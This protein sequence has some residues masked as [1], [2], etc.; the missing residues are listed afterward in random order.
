MVIPEKT[1]QMAVLNFI[2]TAF[3][4]TD[5]RDEISRIQPIETS[6]PTII[7]IRDIIIAIFGLFTKAIYL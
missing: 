6:T 5:F 3:G 4:M 2:V 1:K 7:K